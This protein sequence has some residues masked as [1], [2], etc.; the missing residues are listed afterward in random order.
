MQRPESNLRPLDHKSD[1]LTTTLSS[2]RVVVM[3]VVVWWCG[4]GGGGGGGGGSGSDGSSSST[5]SRP[6]SKL[7]VSYYVKVS[8]SSYCWYRASVISK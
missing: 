8:T 3:V 7:L 2:Q 6:G 4:G 1:A 5:K